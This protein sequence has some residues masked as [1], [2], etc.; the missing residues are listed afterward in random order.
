VSGCDKRLG[1]LKVCEMLD[2]NK[3]QVYFM[4][5]GLEDR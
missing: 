1:E 5:D 4:Q 2:T 3:L